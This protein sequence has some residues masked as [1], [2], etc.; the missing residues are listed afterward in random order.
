M[1]KILYFVH[2]PPPVHGVSV[3]NQH[4]IT[5]KLLNSTYQKEV[6][7]INF[8]NSHAGMRQ[9]SL[10][11]FLKVIPLSLKLIK[12]LISFKPDLVYFT[13][14]PIGD[15]FKRDLLF[16]F[17]M[18]LLRA[19]IV[20]HL[21]GKGIALESSSFLKKAYKYA[22]NNTNII[23]LSKE[24]TKDIN[25]VK[26][27]AKVH[28]C[29]NGILTPDLNSIIVNNDE[30][31]IKLLFLSNLSPLKGIK[32]YLEVANKLI[33]NGFN[34]E[35]HVAG[36]FTDKFKKEEFD[37]FIVS[38]SSLASALIYHGGVEGKTKWTI[39]KEADILIHP[40]FNDAFPL[41]ILEAIASGC[42]IV[43]TNQGGI[44]D[45]LRNKPYGTIIE[46]ITSDCLYE[47]LESLLEQKEHFNLWSKAALEDYNK[48][49]TLDVFEQTLN[50]IFKKV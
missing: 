34:I 45:I 20:Y 33:E 44:P 39:L 38:S 42:L 3:C 5:S 6:I 19:K 29:A 2:L 15:A 46:K 37:N 43:S 26:G 7:S 16:I 17:I 11:K 49:Y 50:E 1:K 13:L 4:V 10:L 18:K 21:H 8:N 27:N 41:V 14:S 47:N 9:R 25:N 28:L 22:F 24:L 12:S 31:K 48:H 40:T 32:L 36:P 30:K 23:C 35:V